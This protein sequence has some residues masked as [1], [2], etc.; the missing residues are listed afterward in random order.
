MNINIYFVLNKD[1]SKFSNFVVIKH[2]IALIFIN[3]KIYKI[4]YPSCLFYSK[5]SFS[6]R[7][8]Q[9]VFEIQLDTF[10]NEISVDKQQIVFSYSYKV[11]QKYLETI[12]FFFNPESVKF[13]DL[14]KEL[15]IFLK[16]FFNS[17][18]IKLLKFFDSKGENNGDMLN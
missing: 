11:E 6:T 5:N 18:K 12:E 2:L 13:Y 16:K 17:N 3:G 14:K 1:T 9:Q 7:L 10:L 15:D 8:P 4:N